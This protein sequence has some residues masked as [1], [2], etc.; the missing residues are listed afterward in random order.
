MQLTPEQQKQLEMIEQM[1]LLRE[2]EI[3][4]EEWSVKTPEEKE[5]IIGQYIGR[6]MEIN[7][8]YCPPLLEINQVF[9]FCILKMWCLINKV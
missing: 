9:V 6:L 3:T 1:P 8:I 5:R 7:S 2:S 4:A